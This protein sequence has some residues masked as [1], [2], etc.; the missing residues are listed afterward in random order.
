MKVKTRKAKRTLVQVPAFSEKL[1]GPAVLVLLRGVVV[2][3]AIASVSAEFGY[4]MF[5][6]YVTVSFSL[7]QQ[8]AGND[9]G[10]STL[11]FFLLGCQYC[12][13]QHVGC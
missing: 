10:R 5:R 7:H 4:R 13:V 6:K 9:G 3:H 11:T 2:C 8:I 1:A 12:A